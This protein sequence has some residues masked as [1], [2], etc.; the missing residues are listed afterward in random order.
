MICSHEEVMWCPLS[1]SYING[2]YT[3]DK[4]SALL[5]ER[6][7]VFHTFPLWYSF[8]KLWDKKSTE[9]YIY[10]I[11]V[12]LVKSDKYLL[13][14]TFW[15]KNDSQQTRKCKCMALIL[16]RACIWICPVSLE[17]IHQKPDG[18]F[19]VYFLYRWFYTK[20]Y[21]YIHNKIT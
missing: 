10:S 14:K 18:I 20:Y 15:K 8:D 17:I 9:K 4:I 21:A 2:Y 6:F 3:R 19:F 13:K 12:N 16:T 7:S 1:S 5:P 11:F